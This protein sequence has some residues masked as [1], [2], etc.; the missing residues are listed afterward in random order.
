[1]LG[2]DVVADYP[3]SFVGFDQRLVIGGTPGLPA[4]LALFIVAAIIFYYILHKSN[5]GI[6]NIMSGS[7]PSASKF[8]GIGVDRVRLLAFALSGTVSGICAVMITSR[9]GSTISNV[10]LGLELL[11][12][13]VVVLGGTDIFGGRGAISGTVVS[14]FAIMAVREAL[15]IQDVNGQVQDSAVGL[16][17]ILTVLVPRIRSFYI[18]KRDRQKRF[19]EA[20]AKA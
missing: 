1:M 12:I 7:N 18:D 10:G 4:P 5:Y 3:E 8:S 19:N 6:K 2:D 13:T 20:Q 15:V 14:L 16:L 9:L 11:A 17:L